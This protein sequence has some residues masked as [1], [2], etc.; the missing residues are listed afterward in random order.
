MDFSRFA[1]ARIG[2]L[3]FMKLTPRGLSLPWKASGF[4]DLAD[5]R[6]IVTDDK[7]EVINDGEVIDGSKVYLLTVGV[8]DDG[9]YD[10]DTTDGHIVDPY[11]VGA[12]DGGSGG[13]GSGGGGCAAGAAVLPALAA[14]AGA[15]VV[16]GKRRRG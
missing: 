5:E 7:G 4:D 10:W 13:S 9:D 16:A 11:A 14:L 6:Y 8:K 2:D 1:G 3:T 12:P 15:L